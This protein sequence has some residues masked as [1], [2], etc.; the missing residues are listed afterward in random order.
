MRQL[1]WWA[2]LALLVGCGEGSADVKDDTA[3]GDDTSAADPDVA[4][5][6][7]SVDRATCTQQQS[8]GEVWDVQAT[9]DDPQGAGTVRGGMMAIL[10][11]AGGELTT[12]QILAC[13]S[14]QCFGSFR[15]DSTGV[16]CSTSVVFRF[17]VTDV[18]GYA[19]DPYDHAP[20]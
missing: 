9:V 3:G 11:A 13:G 5:S 16:S 17:V 12:P 15:A 18:D 2:G 20:S 19:S 14:G 7:V 6:I 8:A 4:P 1:G 10:N